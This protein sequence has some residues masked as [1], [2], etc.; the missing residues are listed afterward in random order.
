M[1][2][3]KKPTGLLGYFVHQPQ[4]LKKYDI[5]KDGSILFHFCLLC[6]NL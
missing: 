4:H 5:Q 6:L 3:E 2:R 1:F